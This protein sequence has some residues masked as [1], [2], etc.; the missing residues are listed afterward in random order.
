MTGDLR[1]DWSSDNQR[2]LSAELELLGHLLAG[3]TDGAEALALQRARL[4][5]MAQAMSSPPALLV[6]TE[7]FGLSPFERDLL[8]LCAGVEMQG[9]FADLCARAQG[10]GGKSCPTFGL[11][12]GLLQQPHWSALSP[13]RP[14][15]Y[16]RLLE[17][18]NNAGLSDSALRIDERVLHYLAGIQ[19]LD[20]RLYGYVE[21]LAPVA[22]DDLVASHAALV[23]RIAALWSEPGNGTTPAVRLCGG[24]QSAH[25]S[26]AR[27]A[28]HGAG[29]QLY[30]AEAE[31]LPGNAQE[32]DALLRL[33]L[34]EACLANG[35]L[36]LDC[37]RGA[38]G[39]HSMELAIARVA[40]QV[41][42]PLIVSG[43]ERW[44]V[45][46]RSVYRFDVPVLSHKE[47]HRLWQ[48]ALGPLSA[49]LNGDIDRLVSQ[50]RLP[51]ATIRS[52]CEE[53]NQ[54]ADEQEMPLDQRLWAVCRNHARS[55][56]DELAQRIEPAAGWQDL[57]LPEAQRA[58][59]HQIA[60]HVNHRTRVYD[61]W[62][63]AGKCARGLG[64]H[65]LF[66]GASGTGKTM[67]A[68]VLAN[69]L[70]LDL[71]RIDLSQVVSK[72]IGETEKNLRTV[73]D[74]AETSGAILL[75]DEADALFGKRSE[76]KD[77]HDRYANIEVGYLLQRME[78]YRGL[79][80]LTTNMKDALDAAFLRRIRFV[81]AFPFPDSAQRAEIW[82]RIFPQQTP[83]QELDPDKL[84]RLNITGGNIHNIAL[85][86]A[87]LAAEAGVSVRMP[88]LL[89][90]ARCEY[91]KLEKPF[92]EIETRGWT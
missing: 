33:W 72:Y 40:Q 80:I 26:I 75:F 37:E 28:A 10:D 83:T 87:F 63:F 90:A 25:R 77:S 13:G 86:A 49:K 89:A 74:V 3:S 7:M 15:R 6:L 22:L 57:V 29:M 43:R 64:I 68:E 61:S 92:S 62:G 32:L 12:L 65:A 1:M 59:L 8:L 20:Q 51:P 46:D 91:S 52:A 54:P 36:L 88:H 67:A 5:E 58:T 45:G 41:R 31:A 70:G 66:T 18:G 23:R 78:A 2:Y 24:D 17:T 81:V 69:E 42:T 30:L 27:A 44:S 4:N 71:Y 56:L 82:K 85:Q 47:Q 84:S 60:L 35:V 34:R 55:G 76:V 79:A 11:A 16:W 53:L 19:H 48:G 73:F 38:H 9:S 50:F 39:E 14:L 21:P